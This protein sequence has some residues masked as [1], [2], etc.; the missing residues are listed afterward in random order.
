MSYEL[1]FEHEL[2]DKHFQRLADDNAQGHFHLR[3]IDNLL[4][5][6]HP[7][8]LTFISGEPATGKTTLL[9]QLADEAAAEGFICVFNTLEVAIHQLIA[10]SL[11]RLSD[12][13]ISVSDISKFCHSEEVSVLLEQYRDTL[14]PNFVFMDSATSAIDLGATIAR[15]QREKNRPVILLQDYLQIMP[16]DDNQRII[17]ERLAVKESVT[18]LRRIANAHNVPVIAISSIN[19]ANYG[20][21]TPNLSALGASSSVEYAADTIIHLGIDGVNTEERFENSNRPV[22]PI[23]ATVLKNRYGARGSARL[24]F[25]A[26]H[27]RFSE[28]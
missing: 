17:D 20:K 26:V 6:I 5:G 21:S 22:R 24:S 2:L 28:R 19:R 16:T 12:N 23:T 13:R 10:K 9:G 27:A 25:D 1:K 7:G 4:Q 11:S 15:I 18:G 14:A 3:A 8:R